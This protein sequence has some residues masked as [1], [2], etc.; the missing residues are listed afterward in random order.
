MAKNKI[1]FTIILGISLIVLIGAVSA[2]HCGD[3]TIDEHLEEEC[4]DGN[5]VNGD[6]CSSTCIIEE[7][8][9]FCGDGIKQECEECDDG[10][11]I[12]GDGC[13]SSCLVEEECNLEL[14]KSVDHQNAELGDIL[15]YTL[16]YKNTGD[17]ICTG[18]GVKIQDTLDEN[19]LYTGTYTKNILN[20]VD[21]QGLDFAWYTIPGYDEITN[22]LTWNAHVVSPNEEGT[23]TFETEVLTPEQCGDFEISNYFKA[24]SDQEDWKSSNTVNVFINNDCAPFCGDEIVNGDEEC[25]DGSLNGILCEAGYDDFCEYCSN[26]CELITLYGEYCGDEIV[27]GCEECDDGNTVSGDGCS[28]TCIIEEE[29]PFCGDG[30]VDSGEECDDGIL[31]GVVCDNSEEDCTY[32]NSICETITRESSDDD[33]RR[34]GK[35]HEFISTCESNWECSSWGEC[36][37]GILQRAC[38]DTNNCGTSLN[39]PVK[40]TMCDLE[41]VK[42]EPE[43]NLKNLL[44]LI[45]ILLLLM[46]I[47]IFLIALNKK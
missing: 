7:E 4:D 19:L 38:E 23:I 5:T 16:H 29:E 14:T 18:G 34:S 41:P 42:M 43:K 44:W 40:Q 8:E 9:P 31:N 15:T 20:D 17:K 45:L 28:S 46:I 35:T 22:T 6:G 10:N 32:C 1:I 26:D 27:N 11:T 47:V 36:E 39:K 37:D 2:C 24:W 12:N 33:D 3:G 30:F 13:S 25:D 21:S